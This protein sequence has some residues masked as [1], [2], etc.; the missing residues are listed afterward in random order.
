MQGKN[1]WDL[2][3][4]PPRSNFLWKSAKIGQGDFGQLIAE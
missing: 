1:Y 3:V 4:C 2:E